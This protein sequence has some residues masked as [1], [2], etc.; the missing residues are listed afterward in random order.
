M[1]V[2]SIQDDIRFMFRA[3]IGENPFRNFIFRLLEPSSISSADIKDNTSVNGPVFFQKLVN[4]FPSEA[5]PKIIAEFL[6]GVHLIVRA[7]I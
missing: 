6:Y 1:H 3:D 4:E 2:R 5:G 7:L